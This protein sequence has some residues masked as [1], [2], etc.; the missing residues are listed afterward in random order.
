MQH[1]GRGEQHV[2][3]RFHHRLAHSGGRVVVVGRPTLEQCDGGLG[4]QLCADALNNLPNTR[5]VRK[6]AKD[7]DAMSRFN[8]GDERTADVVHIAG[9]E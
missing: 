3:I 4:A 2:K 6:I 9:D 8:V 5:V 1:A 7:E